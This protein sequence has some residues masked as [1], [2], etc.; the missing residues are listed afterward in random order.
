MVDPFPLILVPHPQGAGPLLAESVA[1]ERRVS[2]HLAF[3]SF[4]AYNYHMANA[5]KHNDT[6]FNIGD[7]IAI[8]YK[9][10]EGEKTRLQTFEGILMQV[11]G[12]SDDTRMFTVR[13]LS[14][15]GVG[16][17]RIIPVKSPFID[18]ISLVKKSNFQKSRLSFVRN[19][20]EQQ[21]RHKLYRKQ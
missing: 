3:S 7:T 10:K 12:A 4:I 15:T 13:K 6:V 1:A 2:Q 17:E 8:N 18:S 14:K 9:I 16:I 5:L 20:S 21:L 11:K 19:L